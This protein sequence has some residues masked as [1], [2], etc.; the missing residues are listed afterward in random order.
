MQLQQFGPNL[1]GNKERSYAQAANA[2]HFRWMACWVK[3]ASTGA[4]CLLE[5]LGILVHQRLNCNQR[6]Q[7]SHTFH[8]AK[9]I[10]AANTWRT[11]RSGKMYVES[12]GVCILAWNKWQHLQ[13]SGK[14]WYLPIKFQSSQADWKCQQSSTTPMAHPGNRSVLLKQDWLHHDWWLLQQIHHC[15]E[16]SKQFHTC[17]DKGTRYGFHRIWMTTH[18]EKWQWTVLQFQGILAVPQVL[19][20][21][22]HQQQPTTIQ[23]A[24]DLLK[25]LWAFWRSWWKSPPKMGNHGTMDWCSTVWYQFPAPSHHH[26]KPSQGGNRGFHFLRSLHQLGRLW[27]VPGFDR[28]SSKD[29]RVPE[30]TAWNSN[31]DS[32]F[33]VKE[34]H[35]NV[36]KTGTIDQ[37]ARE[38]DS[39]W[40]WFPDDSILRRTRQMIKPRSLPFHFQV[41]DSEQ[42]EEHT[43]IQDLQQSAEFP[44]NVPRHGTA[45]LTDRQS[46]CTSIP[47]DRNIIWEAG[48][49]Y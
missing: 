17:H 39:Y 19:S 12:Q 24:M 7:S 10:L 38:P 8:F 13:S 41:G 14:M 28:N 20:S 44:D 23:G 26:L 40:V 42:K 2:L 11:P 16:T 15:Q 32:L 6:F 25:L 21:S 3:A 45:S 30:I 5:L 4:P 33:F 34:V 22:A 29:S 36:W 37:P 18:A 48:H 43:G 27:K 47:W 46:S 1:W 35:R 31:Q 49:C 9:E